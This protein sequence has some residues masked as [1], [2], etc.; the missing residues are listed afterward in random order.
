[1]RGK[2]Q[3]KFIL[4]YFSIIALIGYGL[5]LFSSYSI[6]NFTVEQFYILFLMIFVSIIV[7]SLHDLIFN[8]GTWLKQ[9]WFSVFLIFWIVIAVPGFFFFVGSTSFFFKVSPNVIMIT[10]AIIFFIQLAISTW[11]EVNS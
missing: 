10:I 7:F 11:K 6:E 3:T 5:I 9:G 1:M 4:F 8:K 2:Y